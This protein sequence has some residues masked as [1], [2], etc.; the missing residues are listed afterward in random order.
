M[1]IELTLAEKR[2]IRRLKEVASTWPATLWL[3]SASA[4][5]AVMRYGEDGEQMMDGE[6]FDQE[7]VVDTIDIPNDGGDW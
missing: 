7:Y 2:A 3:L 5:L 1:D 6:G 4:T